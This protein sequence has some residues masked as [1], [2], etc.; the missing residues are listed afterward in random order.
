VNKKTIRVKPLHNLR[1]NSDHNANLSNTKFFK[2]IVN[3]LIENKKG[4]IITG[5]MEYNHELLK[6]IKQLSSITKYPVLADG[7][8]HLRFNINKNDITVISNFNLIF[9]SEKFLEA[10]D[11]EVILQFGRTPT[12]SL[13]ET[14]FEGTNARRYLI[15]HYGDKFDPTRNSTAIIGSDPI[16]FC[17]NL[18][19]ALKNAKFKRHKSSWL[20]DFIHA[21][22][23]TE[24]VKLRSLQKS[25]FPNEISTMT[26]IVDFLPENSNLVIGN[27]LPVRDLDSFVS[28]TGKKLFLHFNRGASGIDGVTS[29]ALG[30][31]SRRKQ[32]ILFTGDL[33]FLHDLNAL[34]IAVKYSLPISIV[35]IN[36]NGG[37]IFK[38][39]P[40][41]K[42]FNKLN[43]Y[44]ITPHNLNLAN[45]V[46]S[47]GI[48]Y[49]LVK[50]RRD[51]KHQLSNILSKKFP[52]VLE[53]QTDAVKSVDI[54]KKISEES[55]KILNKEF[56]Q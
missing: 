34:S 21:D 31:S 14:F 46:N 28:R 40:I 7:L 47:F 50:S 17:K 48:K 26:E 35:I 8:S 10:H 27:S 54:R 42:K 52:V 30:I 53:I 22:E 6:Q 36:N 38:S 55:Q 18:I 23:E 43:D 9:S 45:I 2:T 29:T 32:T 4:I 20:K 51:L 13:L 19:S 56:E 16:Y 37:G 5:P 24:K 1:H 44:F 49:K 3:E 39:L 12:S 41:A 33:S 11:P 25:K 15:N